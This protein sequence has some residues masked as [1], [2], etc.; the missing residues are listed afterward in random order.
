VDAREETLWRAGEL[1]RLEPADWRQG[2]TLRC[3][4]ERTE[5]MHRR[6]ADR[7][8]ASGHDDFA[9]KA[10]RQADWLRLDLEMPAAARR[11]YAM[12][13]ELRT[14]TSIGEFYAEVLD[15]ALALTGADRGN[16]QILGA[17]T[18]SLRIV[19]EHGFSSEFLEYF[20]LV[21]DDHSA[22]GRAA[23]TRAQM[24]IPDVTTEPSF[25]PHLDIAAASGFRAVQSTPIINQA[26]RLIGVVSTHFA[27][28]YSPAD[29]NLQFIERFAE[30]AGEIIVSHLKRP[31]LPVRHAV[32]AVDGSA[33][34][35]REAAGFA[36]LDDAADPDLDAPAQPGM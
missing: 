28:P 2:R 22:C 33:R 11:F 24:G 29:H 1:A 36:M 31:A 18:G 15:G 26:D 35:V 14:V 21:N 27:H 12:T 20:A 10:E 3:L 30:I 32:P 4:L 25:A 13:R 17:A 23:K 16:L 6:S 7:L 8:R 9:R 5:V 34:R 19:A